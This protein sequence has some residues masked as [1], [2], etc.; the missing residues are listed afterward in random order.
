MVEEEIAML[1]PQN[2]EEMI[3]HGMSKPKFTKGRPKK[4]ETIKTNLDLTETLIVELD[5]IAEFLGSN[6]QGVIKHFILNGLSEYYK[7]MN[8]RKPPT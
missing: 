3:P 1:K 6:R 7:T 2:R 5:L 8:L 4:L